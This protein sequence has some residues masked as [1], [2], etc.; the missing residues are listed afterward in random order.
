MENF[1]ELQEKIGYTFKDP[2]HLR[3]ALIHSSY[4]NEHGMPKFSDNERYE[5]LGDSVLEMVSSDFLFHNYPDQNEGQ[6]SKLRASL[7]CEMALADVAVSLS[8]GD[9]IFL[10]NGEEKT[11]G[12]QLKSILSDA[13]ESVIGAIYLDGGI[14]PADAFIRKFILTDIENR[15]LFYDAKTVLQELVQ[16]GDYGPL[17]YEEMKETGPEHRKTFYMRALV[18]SRLIGEG[19]GATKKA[20]EQEAAYRGLLLL[21]QEQEAKKLR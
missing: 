3:H 21:R 7:V 9:Y 10:S 12:R 4:A 15:T 13:L 11:G 19:S 16:G 14:V 18:G 8:I 2:M 20:A 5:F 17:H 1:L 6:M